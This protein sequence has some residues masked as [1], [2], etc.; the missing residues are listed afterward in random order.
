MNIPFRRLVTS[1]EMPT[2]QNEDPLA[3]ELLED[4]SMKEGKCC[5]KKED[6]TTDAPNIYGLWR[7][8][9]GKHR[10]GC[11]I[12]YR[13]SNEGMFECIVCKI[14]ELKKNPRLIEYY[15]EDNKERSIL[16]TKWYCNECLSVYYRIDDG[17]GIPNG[18]HACNEIVYP[19]FLQEFP[20][21]SKE[22]SHKNEYLP[23][24]LT[25][26]YDENIIWECITC[27]MEWW[28]TP[29]NRANY[30]T[31]CPYCNKRLPYP[32]KDS[33]A[34]IYPK[35]TEEWEYSLN[36]VKPTECFSTEKNRL[37]YWKCKDCGIIYTLSIADKIQRGN[38]C[39]FCENYNFSKDE[40]SE[41]YDEFISDA[42]Q[43]SYF[44]AEGKVPFKWSC[45]KCG[46]I[47]NATA[48]ER[49]VIGK[50][51]PYCTDVS[52]AIPGKTSF[53]A[54][55]PD[56]ESE[57]VHTQEGAVDTDNILPIDYRNKRFEWNCHECNMIW[58][59]SI[60]ERTQQGMICPYCKGLK[61]IPGKTSI[62]ALYP[63]LINNEWK[64]LP[65][66]LLT[67][68]DCELSDSSKCVWWRCN[69]CM[70]SYPYIIK[71]RVRDYLRG[72]TS[73]H[74]C[75]GLRRRKNHFV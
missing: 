32:D 69:R 34:A 57:Y 72:K 33:F 39:Y 25:R 62:L 28:E 20:V 71:K 5:P 1:T 54:L 8:D 9:K 40:T 7:C 61:A 73:C 4:F 22:W 63:D 31:G 74:Y 10:W 17:I 3:Y 35:I 14:Q 45:R 52:L 15:I 48:Y 11:L 41:I 21:L 27:N 42:Y 2:L 30:D 37:R 18:E 58:K 60:P 46:E 50:Q 70:K 29:Q 49:F 75:K 38:Y 24:Q 51:C 55:F 68:P 53:K 13:H 44:P 43:H 26:F 16:K 47:W 65:N 67:N 12:K 56:I 59:A 6:I 36:T 64:K 23:K 66:A 19:S